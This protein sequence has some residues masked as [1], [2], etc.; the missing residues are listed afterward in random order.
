MKNQKDFYFK[1][2]KPQIRFR[3]N[4]YFPEHFTFHASPISFTP[5]TTLSETAIEAD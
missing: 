1:P 5:L 3:R 4:S 2:Q